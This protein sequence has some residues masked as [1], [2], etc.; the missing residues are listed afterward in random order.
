MHIISSASKLKELLRK[1]QG[2]IGFVATM[3][4]L[5]EGHLT[6]IRESKKQNDI[7]VVSI[8]VNPTQFLK[9]ED[10]EKYPRRDEADK[11]ICEVA[12]VDYLFMPT[13]DEMYTHDEAK[14]QA[15]EVRGY[16]LEGATRPGHFS[17][18]L[19][20]VLKLLN[21]V[22]PTHAYFGKKDAQQ[23]FLIEQM[24]RSYFLDVKIVPVDTVRESDGLA[25][26]SRNVYL[27]QQERQEALKI[28]ASLNL[29]RSLIT[30]G[31][32]DAKEITIQMKKV[33]APLQIEYVVVVSRNF[34]Y[35][36][37]VE[38]GDTIILVEVI[39]GT[40]RLLDNIWV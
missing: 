33:L 22:A 13:A 28:P 34:E 4:A 27:S 11:K 36:K 8:F 40:T 10:L 6:L 37:E 14:M 12:G 23:L 30:Q 15:P 18:V 26:S 39:V 5:H 38:I 29:A 1:E 19:T 35:R 7:T 32:R 2:S 3:G 17:G 16:I 9:G 21:I 24:A 31:I 25:L 20:V